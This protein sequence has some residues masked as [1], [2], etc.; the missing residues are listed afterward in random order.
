MDYLLVYLLPMLYLLFS[1][2]CWRDIKL[3][4]WCMFILTALDSLHMFK[5]YP[6][7]YYWTSAVD[8]MTIVFSFILSNPIRRNVII[9]VSV[10]SCVLNLYEASSMYQTIFYP[11]YNIIQFIITEIILI[12]AIYKGTRNNVTLN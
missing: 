5:A 8:I 12:A 6:D 9:F 10:V 3:F 4:C 11:H 2:I 7:F 1:F